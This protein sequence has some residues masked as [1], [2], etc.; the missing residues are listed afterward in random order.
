MIDMMINR[1]MLTIAAL[2]WTLIL[3]VAPVLAQA[4]IPPTLNF[5]DI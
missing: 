1:W 2:G 4:V 5:Q 3:T